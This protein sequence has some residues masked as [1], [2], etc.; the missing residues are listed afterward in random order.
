MR[1]RVGWVEDSSYMLL[2]MEIFPSETQHLL[3]RV[4]FRECDLLVKRVC[5]LSL[6]PT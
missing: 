1:Y 6:N 2:T 4:G 3:M 5:I